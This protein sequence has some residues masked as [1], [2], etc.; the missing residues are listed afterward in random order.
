[1]RRFAAALLFVG[2]GLAGAGDAPPV[3]KDIDAVLRSGKGAPEGRAA[4]ERLSQAGPDGLLPILE[5]MQKRDVPTQNWLRTA[6]DRIAD[7]AT[8]AGGKGINADELLRFVND[9]GKDGR[10]RRLALE[11]AE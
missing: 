5:A 3:R 6:F 4:W 10:S 2:V 1:M 8:G 7:R 11:L 9:T